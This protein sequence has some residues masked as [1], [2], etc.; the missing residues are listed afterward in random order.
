MQAQLMSRSWGLWE[1]IINAHLCLYT[2]PLNMLAKKYH[3]NTGSFFHDYSAE[4]ASGLLNAV[5]QPTFAC[6]KCEMSSKLTR[7]T[8][9]RRPFSKVSIVDFEQVNVSSEVYLLP[10]AK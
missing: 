3:L 10:N 2:E 7:K 4:F 9:E 6:S 5:A 1:R 8:P